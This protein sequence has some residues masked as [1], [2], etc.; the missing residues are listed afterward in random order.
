MEPLQFFFIHKVWASVLKI[1]DMPQIEQKKKK[2]TK[3]QDRT[4]L[5]MMD[6][7]RIL[8]NV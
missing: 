1:P 7:K 3:K 5:T 6:F 8:I 4:T 2:T